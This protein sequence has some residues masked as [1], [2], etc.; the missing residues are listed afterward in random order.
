M[1][2]KPQLV[3]SVSGLVHVPLQRIW[4]VRH[5]LGWQLP[6]TH[7]LPAPQVREL[8]RKGN[9]LRAA[10]KRDSVV[11]WVVTREGRARIVGSNHFH[12]QRVGA[13]AGR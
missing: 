6:I 3:P 8:R 9:R 10:K 7:W 4:P 5:G 11:G 12:H 2:Q 13:S 1:L